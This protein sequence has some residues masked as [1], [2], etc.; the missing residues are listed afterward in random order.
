M[1]E[2]PSEGAVGAR[3]PNASEEVE[4]PSGPYITRTRA[5]W[6]A[7]AATLPVT[8]SRQALAKLRGVGDPTDL[9]EIRDVYL[10]LTELLNLYLDHTVKLH[11]ASH[12]YL[13]LKVR[14]TPFV[15]G[16]AGSVAVGKSTT[17][18]VLRELLAQGPGRPKVDL[19]TTD[20]FLHPNRVLTERGLMT[21]KGFPESY[22]RAALLKFVMDVK[23]GEPEVSVPVYSHL[24][25]D[26]VPGQHV[27][28]HRPDI[29]IVEGLNVLEPARRRSDGSTSL[30]VSDFFDFSIYVD[31]AT[32]HIKEWYIS[33]FLALR[34]TAFRD[35]RSFFVRYAGLSDA[36]ARATATHIWDTINGPN[37]VVNIRPTRGRATAIFR[38]AEN[39]QVSWVRIRKV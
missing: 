17:A 33:R 24:A 8:V 23:S 14:R 22:D 1:I 5:D 38:K 9:P 39:H 37:L 11:A 36:E 34:E 12:A 25:Y 31:A 27:V 16:I 2:Q 15:I 13:G 7:I 19:V 26:I 20:G 10:P 21:R 32:T 4:E 35:P 6:A 28:I 29:L 30:A 3:H 18:R